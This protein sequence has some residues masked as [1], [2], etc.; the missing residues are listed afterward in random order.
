MKEYINLL[1]N[2]AVNIKVP[3]RI[4]DKGT[5]TPTMMIV[6]AELLLDLTEIIKT[7]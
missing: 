2:K 6:R 7:T 3:I 1:S 5:A 4:A